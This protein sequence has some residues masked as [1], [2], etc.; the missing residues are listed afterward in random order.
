[1]TTLDY[2]QYIILD[3]PVKGAELANFLKEGC[4]YESNTNFILKTMPWCQKYTSSIDSDSDLARKLEELGPY[5][6]SIDLKTQLDV[7]Y[8]E[9][10]QKELL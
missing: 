9:W 5:I 1:M 2:A 4:V 6:L 10:K 8:K 7:T 3:E